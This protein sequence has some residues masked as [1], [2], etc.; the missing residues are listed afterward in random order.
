MLKQE[1]YKAQGRDS[2]KVDAPAAGARPASR[3]WCVPLYKE[4]IRD[5]ERRVSRV[6]QW[7]SLYEWNKCEWRE[8]VRIYGASRERGLKQERYRAQGNDEPEENIDGGHPCGR[9]AFVRGTWNGQTHTST[10]V[11]LL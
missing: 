6:S 3:H 8:K 9:F 10:T 1:R 5:S 7:V 11:E 2:P 4:D